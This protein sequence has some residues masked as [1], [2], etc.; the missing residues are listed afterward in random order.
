MVFAK[1]KAGEMVSKLTGGLIST[2]PT[3]A[4][5]AKQMATELVT[6]KAGE[7]TP[8]VQG[9]ST[10][11]VLRAGECYERQQVGFAAA[12]GA[13][14]QVRDAFVWREPQCQLCSA[15][16]RYV[17]LAVRSSVLLWIKERRF[18]GFSI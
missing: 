13:T 14:P 16:M 15:M 8:P 12:I 18:S 7:A 17:S 9:W 1:R 3:D 11:G 2:V 10:A 4:E 5:Q 6:K